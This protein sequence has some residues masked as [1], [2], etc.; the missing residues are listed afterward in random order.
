MAHMVKM[1]FTLDE[2]TVER[3]RRTA[4][5]LGKPKSQVIREAV[6]EYEARSTSLGDEERAR[7]LAIVDRMVEEPPTRTAAEVD[8]ELG[9]IRAARR[10]WGRHGPSRRRR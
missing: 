4:S 8:A 1:T 3:L 6:R 9:A 5:R 7:M 10:R 2:Q